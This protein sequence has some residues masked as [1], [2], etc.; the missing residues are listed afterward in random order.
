MYIEQIPASGVPTGAAMYLVFD[1]GLK[2]SDIPG[3]KG[4]KWKNIGDAAL[5]RPILSIASVER[6]MNATDP[7]MPASLRALFGAG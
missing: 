5:T 6:S 4:N 1:K 2:I 7:N 3:L